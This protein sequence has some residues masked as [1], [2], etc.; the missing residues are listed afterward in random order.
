L[1]KKEPRRRDGG[2]ADRRP[3]LREV[4]K[5]AGITP[6]T[7][8]YVL[9]GNSE[10]TISP[11]TKRRVLSAAGKL[12]YRPHLAARSLATGR[13][14]TIGLCFGEEA[15]V[16]FADDYDRE[17]LLGVLQAAAEKSYALQIIDA[18]G[19]QMPHHVDGWVAAQTPVDFELT[20]LSGAPVVFLDPH[21]RIQGHT[22]VWADNAAGG[23][24]LAEQIAPRTSSVL[25]MLHEPL[26]RTARAYR[27]RFKSFEKRWKQLAP[28][29]RIHTDFLHPNDSDSACRGFLETWTR[30][31]EKKEITH[32]A[33]MSDMQAARIIMLLR[34]TGLRVPRDFTI[35]GFDNTLHSRLCLPTISTIDLH[36]VALAKRS[37]SE[38]FR[39]LDQ[40]NSEFQPPPPSWLER[41]STGA[42]S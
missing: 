8:S 21:D 32:I 29:K 20:R 34:Q 37:V 18:P 38:L 35:S 12:G 16:P 19:G 4:A 33:C 9:S 17:V 41:Q 3:T 36:T 5:L 26:T 23:R 13:T 24:L 1:K 28:S 31:L 11:A 30:P 40:A 15:V 2:R 22:C 27:E 7:A 10:V 14:R 39:L 25:V 6:A 42:S